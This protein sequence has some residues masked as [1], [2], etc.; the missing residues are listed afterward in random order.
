M[1]AN[2]ES[3]N[4][5]LLENLYS[6]RVDKNTIFKN[7]K[8]DDAIKMTNYIDYVTRKISKYGLHYGFMNPY[9]FENYKEKIRNDEDELAE[10]FLYEMRKEPVENK[11]EEM[12]L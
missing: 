5:P 3:Y 4:A 10:Y 9:K 7:F 8:W 2:V 1:K 6:S 11:M 12:K